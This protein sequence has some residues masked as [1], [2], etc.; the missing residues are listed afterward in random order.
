M[1]PRV[2]AVRVSFAVSL[3]LVVFVLI[4]RT[5]SSIC[6]LKQDVP[7]PQL[8]AQLGAFPALDDVSFFLSIGPLM[9]RSSLSKC[10]ASP[11]RC[12]SIA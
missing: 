11:W 7:R 2:L 3:R 5:V 6:A 4:A 8:R 10:L 9:Q 12:V 1:R